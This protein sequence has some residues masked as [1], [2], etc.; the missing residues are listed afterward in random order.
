MSIITIGMLWYNDGQYEYFNDGKDQFI[1]LTFMWK[2]CRV[3]NTYTN[4]CKL[5]SET[6]KLINDHII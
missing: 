6:F 1:T 4:H 5:Q 3:I 2:G